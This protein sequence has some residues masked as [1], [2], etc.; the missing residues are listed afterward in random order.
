MRRI[1]S[2]TVRITLG[3]VLLVLY[4]VPIGQ[5]GNSVITRELSRGGTPMTLLML[6]PQWRVERHARE[7]E[8]EASD[9]LLTHPG[10]P[11]PA[12]IVVHG[13][14]G[15][16]PMMTGY[17]YT[18][19]HAGYTVMLIDLPGLGQSELSFDRGAQVQAIHDA[20]EVLR[21]Q[22]EVDASRVGLLGHSMGAGAV[23]RAAM[24]APERY[25]ATV[26]VSPTPE[27][28]SAATPR[29]LLLQAGGW[30]SDFLANANAI[31]AEA[32]GANQDFRSGRAREAR[33]IPRADHVGIV[34]RQASHHAARDWFDRA[35]EFQAAGVHSLSDWRI[36][37]FLLHV[38]G[39]MLIVSA[40]APNFLREPSRE[41]DLMRRP[42]QWAGLAVGPLVATAVALALG[43]VIDLVGLGGIVAGGALA[44]WFLISGVAYIL[45]AYRAPMPRFDDMVRGVGLFLFLAVALGAAGHLTW[46]NFAPTE[47]RLLRWPVFA[48]ACIP[49]FVAT[50][51]GQGDPRG[52]SRWAWW[53]AQSVT[54][55]AGLVLLDRFHPGLGF[56]F[57]PVLPLYFAVFVYVGS[58][59][60]RPWAY[61]VGCGAYL[62]W[63]L[64]VAFPSIT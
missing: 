24:A 46:M 19:A 11:T 29:N 56:S 49:W 20:Y 30:E 6:D 22:P 57:L 55:I 44:F 1:F 8:D 58:K 18:L 28:V 60:R 45:V 9:A 13:F 48:L 39:W 5:A 4:L 34:F 7:H 3:F 47:A 17:G 33:T 10:E 15:S 25:G 50:E 14:A 26:A 40:L 62:G 27:P 51:L 32:G 23:I 35:F 64:A 42:M 53:A 61:G 63:V 16:R 41:K 52:T 37:G 12:V 54:V 43:G 36:V 2:P 31:L 59:V 38:L 21:Q